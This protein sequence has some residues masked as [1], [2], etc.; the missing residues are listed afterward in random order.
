MNRRQ[1]VGRNPFGEKDDTVLTRPSHVRKSSKNPFGEDDGGG[2]RR[3][4]GAARNPFDDAGGA[5]TPRRPTA[6]TIKS[7]AS[8][9]FNPF[10]A[11]AVDAGYVACR[12]SPRGTATSSSFPPRGGSVAAATNPFDGGASP[13][14]AREVAAAAAAAKALGISAAPP[15]ARG[16]SRSSSPSS[17]SSGRSRRSS[18]GPVPGSRREAPQPLNRR[19]PGIQRALSAKTLSVDSLGSV[20]V[21][22]QQQPLAPSPRKMTVGAGAFL[23]S[24]TGRLKRADGEGGASASPGSNMSSFVPRSL[25]R[26]TNARLSALPEDKSF[27]S[28]RRPR[29]KRWRFDGYPDAYGHSDGMSGDFGRAASVANLSPGPVPPSAENGRADATPPPPPAPP[30]PGAYERPPDPPELTAAYARSIPL[31]KF[32]E[33]AAARA[34]ARVAAWIHDCGMF[35]DLAGPSGSSPAPLPSLSGPASVGGISTDLRMD[36]EVG[37][38]A[39]RTREELTAVTAALNEGADADA[40]EVRELV[41]AIAVSAGRD[42]AG[43]RR[44]CTHISRSGT[45]TDGDRDRFLLAGY[46]RLRGAVDARRNLFRVFRELEFFAHMPATCERLRERLRS[47]EYKEDEMQAIRGVA[48]EHVELEALLVEAE[49]G[50]RARVGGGDAYE[51]VYEDDYDYVQGAL[52]QRTAEGVDRFL[53]VHVK[54]VWDLGNE[55]RERILSGVAGSFELVRSDPA[56]MV[57]LVEAVEVYERAAEEYA[58]GNGKAVTEEDGRRG[59][60]QSSL[61]FTDMRAAALSQIYQDFEWRGLEVFRTIHNKAVEEDDASVHSGRDQAQFTAQF[62]MVLGAATKLVSDI[63]LVRTEMAPCFAP[64][65][66]VD[67]L[68]SSCVA[69]ICSNQILEQVGGP[70]G[71]R[72][73]ELAVTQLLELV[74]WIEFFRSHM[75]EMFPKIATLRSSNKTYFDTRPDLFSGSRVDMESATDALSWVD[76]LLDDVHRLAQEEFLQRMRDQTSEWLDK[77][78]AGPHTQYRASNGRLT[79]SLCEDVFSLVTVQFRTVRDRLSP[80]SHALA[81][82]VVL[83][84]NNVRKKQLELRDG[85]LLTLEAT[86]MAA[87]DFARMSERCEEV[88]EEITKDCEFNRDSLEVIEASSAELLALFS[89]DAV[90]SAQYTHYYVFEPIQEV[91]ENR[92]FSLEWEEALTHNDLALTLVRTLDDFMADLDLFLDKFLVRK[93]RKWATCFKH[94]FTFQGRRQ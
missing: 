64:H 53:S 93:V 1:S 94:F 92:L 28:R 82:A 23:T 88:V 41:D 20:N 4:P 22:Q 6:P 49:A 43:L 34:A 47:S 84:L 72:L 83:V 61:R 40:G 7:E 87:N 10:D 21:Q 76:N 46:P 37:R 48:V 80:S 44:M 73:P 90:Y 18:K 78:Y 2:S 58:A 12:S 32:E 16:S 71:T 75:E 45:E 3:T 5:A 9:V 33:E 14:A 29:G 51:V 25:T 52:G 27:R 17:V 55:I 30:P 54:N 26:G 50:L 91:I 57:A 70:E 63:D 79:T 19:G 69:H 77:V 89:T 86:C 60:P 35:D 66:A 31:A 85:F 74:A 24:L 13:A 67:V 15:H 42:L 59:Q 62:S 38:L 11:D 8:A 81:V 65:W 68:W 39:V 36:R 56:G